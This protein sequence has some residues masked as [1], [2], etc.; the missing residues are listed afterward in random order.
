MTLMWTAAGFELHMRCDI[1]YQTVYHKFLHERIA[2]DN[3]FL[4]PNT[5][6]EKAV[7]NLGLRESYHRT[8]DFKTQDPSP[9][10]SKHLFHGQMRP[11][12][13]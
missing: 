13:P 5:D 3:H 8:A 12:S 6:E 11:F 1:Q 4:F 10:S 7:T 9:D 2:Q